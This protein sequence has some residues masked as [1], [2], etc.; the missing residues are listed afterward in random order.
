MHFGAA[1]GI[2]VP[3]GQLLPQVPRVNALRPSA[4]SCW[5]LALLGAAQLGDAQLRSLPLLHGHVH[6][7]VCVCVCVCA[8]TL[9]FSLAFA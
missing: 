6:A 9:L 2:K 8:H 4:G 7:S 5:L 1:S 3:R